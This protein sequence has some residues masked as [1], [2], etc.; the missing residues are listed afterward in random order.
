MRRATAGYGFQQRNRSDWLLQYL[1]ESLYGS[2]A[3]AQPGERTGSVSDC[4]C[5]HIALAVSVGF[6]QGRD[7]RNQLCG[8]RAAR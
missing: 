8:K 4:E 7:L 1:S 6:E 3:Y 2:E 5:V